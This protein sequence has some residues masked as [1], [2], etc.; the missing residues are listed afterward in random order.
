MARNSKKKILPG[1]TEI[2]SP[3]TTIGVN[4]LHIKKLNTLNRTDITIWDFAGQLQYINNHQVIAILA[5]C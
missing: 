2:P 4:V 3:Q 1:K 5:T